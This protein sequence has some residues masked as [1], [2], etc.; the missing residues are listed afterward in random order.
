MNTAYLFGA[1]YCHDRNTGGTYLLI[2]E[3]LNDWDKID[4]RTRAQIVE[5]ARQFARYNQGDWQRLYDKFDE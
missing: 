5:E 2:R 3:M 1:R 4:D